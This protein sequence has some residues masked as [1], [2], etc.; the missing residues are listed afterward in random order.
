MVQTSQ[1]EQEVINL[2][3]IDLLPHGDSDFCVLFD[4]LPSLN[5]EMFP[6]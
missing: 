6:I 4:W 2:P 3:L 5:L 1:A